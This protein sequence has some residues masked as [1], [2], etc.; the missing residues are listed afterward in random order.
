MISYHIETA[1]N[2]FSKVNLSGDVRQILNLLDCEAYKEI[3]LNN[4]D[5]LLID[6]HGLLSANSFTKFFE[7]DN[8]LP[9]P[10]NGLILGKNFSDAQ[11]PIESYNV[12]YHNVYDLQEVFEY[13]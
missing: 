12:K 3:D 2:K 4:G 8:F 10:G 11:N 7:L 9:Q 13:D 6:R 1:E 5:V